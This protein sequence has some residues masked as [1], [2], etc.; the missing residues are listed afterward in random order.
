MSGARIAAAIRQAGERAAARRVEAALER[1][2]AF[3]ASDL[4]FARATIGEGAL[5]LAE[6]GLK[7]RI[8]GRLGLRWAELHEEARVGA[9][10][11]RP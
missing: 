8:G 2:R 9:R 1:A 10:E 3:A 4:P 11:G 5:M 6:R 7:R